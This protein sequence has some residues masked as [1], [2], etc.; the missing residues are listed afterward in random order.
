MIYIIFYFILFYYCDF[1]IK[2]NKFV[3]GLSLGNAGL[4]DCC[5]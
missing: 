2:Q 5:R 4:S 1:S 3:N